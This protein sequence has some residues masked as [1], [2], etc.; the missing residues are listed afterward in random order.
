[1]FIYITAPTLRTFHFS[2]PLLTHGPTLYSFFIGIDP[3]AKQNS[4]YKS[5]ELQEK[6]A[7]INIQEAGNLFRKNLPL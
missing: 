7:Q 1:M 4:N 6:E 5:I 2:I 3:H